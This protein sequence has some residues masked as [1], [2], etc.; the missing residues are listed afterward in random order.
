MYLEALAVFFS[1]L[2]SWAEL[3][4]LLN[5][6]VLWFHHLQN[7]NKLQC[8]PGEAVNDEMKQCRKSA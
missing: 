8:F 7:G 1:G 4:K 3:D 2:T 5:L 6:P